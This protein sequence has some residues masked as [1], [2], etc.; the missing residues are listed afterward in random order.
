MR[1]PSAC[2]PAGPSFSVTDPRFGVE[3]LSRFVHEQLHW[4]LL[5]RGQQALAAMV[6]LQALFPEVPVG[7]PEG[8]VSRSSTYTHLLIGWLEWEALT[9]LVGDDEANSV[10]V[11]WAGDHYRWVYRTVLAERGLLGEIIV[12]HGLQVTS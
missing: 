12:R 5:A 3:L 8:A 6:E 7:H 1:L 11:F 4:M 9:R 2:N 10:M